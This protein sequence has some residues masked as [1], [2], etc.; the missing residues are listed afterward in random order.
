MHLETIGINELIW[1][2][3]KG[4][5]AVLY[6]GASIDPIERSFDHEPNFPPNVVMY[7][8]KTTNMKYAENRLLA[9]CIQRQGCCFNIQQHSNVP[10]DAGSVYA[11]LPYHAYVFPP[12]SV[13]M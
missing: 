12:N 13:P 5:V 3:E 9:S 2:V 4:D 11:I 1:I 6:V 7:V 8:A 10:E